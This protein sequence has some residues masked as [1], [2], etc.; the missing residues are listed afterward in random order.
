MLALKTVWV[1]GTRELLFE[2]LELLKKPAALIRRL[3]N[4]LVLY[5]RVLAPHSGWRARAVAYGVQ[6]AEAPV[7][8]ALG[9]RGTTS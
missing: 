3:R 1:D 6:P 7:A 4:N 5:H 2:P 8:R 9:P